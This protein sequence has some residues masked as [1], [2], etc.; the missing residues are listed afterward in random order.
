MHDARAVANDLL[1]RAGPAGF[2]PVQLQ[3]LAYF[4]HA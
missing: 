3:A 2:T 1:R 4:A